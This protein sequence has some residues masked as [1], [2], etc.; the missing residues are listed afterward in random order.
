M[1]KSINNPEMIRIKLN[2]D[3]GNMKINI[4]IIMIM[5]Q[6]KIQWIIKQLNR[7]RFNQNNEWQVLQIIVR[8][9]RVINQQLIVLG[10]EYKFREES[11]Q[12]IITM[13]FF[14]SVFFI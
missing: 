3:I 6:L 9:A 13:L 5:V 2:F 14:I 4:K 1:K 7:I 12:L 8:N 11:N 10:I